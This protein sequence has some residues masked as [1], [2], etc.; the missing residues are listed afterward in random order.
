ML[1][2]IGRHFV[3]LQQIQYYAGIDRPAARSHHEAVERSEP[4]GGVETFALVQRAQ[5]C[6]VAEMRHHRAFL[7]PSRPECGQTTRDIFEGESMKSVA[8]DAA[9][10][11]LPWDGKAT[12]RR[13]QPMVEGGVEACDLREPRLHG[14]DRPDRREAAGLVQWRK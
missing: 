9:L 2:I 5:A 4:H 8:T 11:V 7:H 12:R 13:G 14:S 6:A 3:F 1:N 10:F